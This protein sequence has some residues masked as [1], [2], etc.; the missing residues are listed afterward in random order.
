[1]ELQ[2]LL[3]ISARD[4]KSLCPRQIL[5]VRLG[6][7]GLAALGFES[8]PA[9]K[10]LLVI[11]ETDGCFVD[12]LG[13]A[14]GCSV[15]HRTLRVEDYGKTAAVFVDTAS[16]S[17]LRIAPALDLRRKAFEHAPGQ[18]NAYLA[19]MQSYRSLPAEEMFSISPV[20]LVTP[21]D[22]ILSRPGL[23]VN[24]ETCGEEIMNEREISRDGR[25]LCR[26]CAQPAYYTLLE[27]APNQRK[28]GS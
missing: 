23:R 3:E 11:S 8:P 2:A 12:G 7:A 26:A 5:G 25:S 16:G 9:E 14:T 20:S 10:R 24:C 15:G 19:Q 28:A 4:H 22:A 6:L 27:P 17:G 13:A 1:M 21:L 18:T